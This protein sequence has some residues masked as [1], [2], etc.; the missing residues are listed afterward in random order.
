MELRGR[1]V[2]QGDGGDCLDIGPGRRSRFGKDDMPGGELGRC[3]GP[4]DVQGVAFRRLQEP[5]SEAE[6]GNRNE[7][8]VSRDRN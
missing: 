7:G 3:R 8:F 6:A 4:E 5:W 1:G 2:G